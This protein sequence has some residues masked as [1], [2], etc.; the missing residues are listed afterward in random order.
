MHPANLCGF[1]ERASIYTGKIDFHNQ[2]IK[3]IVLH[4]FKRLYAVIYR[5]HFV[6]FSPKEPPQS[7]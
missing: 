5:F 4:T 3:R 1:H 6:P 2:K 7:K